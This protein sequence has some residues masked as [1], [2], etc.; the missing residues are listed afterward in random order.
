MREQGLYNTEKDNVSVFFIPCYLN[1]DDGLINKTYYELLIGLDLTLF[2]SYYEPWGYTPL[3]SLAFS[4]PTATTS[5]AG[6]GVWV[7]K[8]Y[9]KPTTGIN[10]VYRNDSN[11]TQVVTEVAAIVR[12]KSRL[13]EEEAAQ[14]KENARDVSTIALWENQLQ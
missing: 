5:L 8:M 13:S 7:E 4:V 2:P 14:A 12:N 11:H 6:F 1:G 10:V 3:E 9:K